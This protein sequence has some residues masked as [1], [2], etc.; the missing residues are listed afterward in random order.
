VTAPG[1]HRVRLNDEDTLGIDSLKLR[2]REI[3]S[4][5]AE[6]IIFVTAESGASLS[7]LRRS[8]KNGS[9]SK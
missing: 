8:S 5:R 2:L 1:N 7:D 3:F 4:I 9:A 6:K